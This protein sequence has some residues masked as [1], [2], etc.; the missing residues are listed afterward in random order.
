MASCFGEQKV[1]MMTSS[2]NVGEGWHTLLHRLEDRLNEL[3][4]SFEILQVKEKFGGLRYYVALSDDLDPDRINEIYL[5]IHG[6]EEESFKICEVCGEPGTN[7][8]NRSG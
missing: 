5:L 3:D 2:N 4:P 1:P 6:T 8:G 7:K